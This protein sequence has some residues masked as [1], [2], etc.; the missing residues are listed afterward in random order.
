M[1]LFSGINNALAF[2]HCTNV[3]LTCT[4]CH[5]SRSPADV[6]SACV[7]ATQPSEDLK[8]AL[9]SG[10]DAFLERS[11]HGGLTT[12]QECE[13]AAQ[14]LTEACHSRGSDVSAD[15]P[16]SDLT[17]EEVGVTVRSR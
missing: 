8:Q 10:G 14:S 6:C 1:P 13:E 12:I 5:V 9:L 15:R 11:L 17:G 3:T 16:Y 4:Q 7:V 2:D